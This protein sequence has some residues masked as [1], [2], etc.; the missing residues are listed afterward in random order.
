[1]AIQM[2]TILRMAFSHAVILLWK[3]YR[4]EQSMDIFG[5]GFAENLYMVRKKSERSF[6][7]GFLCETFPK[8]LFP[9]K[10]TVMS[11]EILSFFG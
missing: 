4:H 6:L 7:L 8:R 1:M 10:V 9:A 2:K 11:T 3:D 5:S